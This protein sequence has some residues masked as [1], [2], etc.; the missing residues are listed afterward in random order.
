MK[1]LEQGGKFLQSVKFGCEQ[2]G[3]PG[4]SVRP[5]LIPMDES[6]KQEMTSVV[7]N[8]RNSLN[9]ILNP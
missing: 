1:T 7:K 2:Q 3:R 5:P 4:G 9:L 8:T 6:L